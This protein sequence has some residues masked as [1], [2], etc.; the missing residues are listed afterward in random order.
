MYIHKFVLVIMLEKPSGV[1]ILKLQ[2]CLLPWLSDILSSE[3]K[4]ADKIQFIDLNANLP[5]LI[6]L[7]ASKS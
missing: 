6:I 5:H 1:M 4:R 2:P 7:N 3:L